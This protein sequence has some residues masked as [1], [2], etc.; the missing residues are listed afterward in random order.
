MKCRIK[1]TEMIR[2]PFVRVI[3]DDGLSGEI[4]IKDIN[5]MFAPLRNEAFFRNASVD[6]HGRSFGWNLDQVGKEI[7][8]CAD[9]TRIEIEAAKVAKIADDY[10]RQRTAAE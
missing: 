8:F 9:A 1:T 3:F 6:P 7:D 10:G 2:Y 4:E 5:G